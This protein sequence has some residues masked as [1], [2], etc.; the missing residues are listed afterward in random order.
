MSER[1]AFGSGTSFAGFRGYA[2]S[3]RPIVSERADFLG[4]RGLTFRTGV[5]SFAFFNARRG[6]R[7]RPFAPS[8]TAFAVLFARRKA[9]N[10]ANAEH[11]AKNTR[12]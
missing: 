12:Q 5:Y 3:L 10:A 9:E 6:F 7:H 11:Y 2:S 8:V 4:L 1:F